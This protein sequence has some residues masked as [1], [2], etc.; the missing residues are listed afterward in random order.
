MASPEKVYHI[1][2]ERARI[3]AFKGREGRLDFVISRSYKDKQG[4]WVRTNSFSAEDL[5]TLLKLVTQAVAE[6]PAPPRVVIEK[7]AQETPLEDDELRF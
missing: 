4:E 7:A 5:P 6:N 3:A 2:G 1:E